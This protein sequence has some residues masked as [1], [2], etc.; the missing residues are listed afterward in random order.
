MRLSMIVFGARHTLKVFFPPERRRKWLPA[1]LWVKVGPPT[2]EYTK[3]WVGL[4]DGERYRWLRKEYAES[5][6]TYLAECVPSENA[7]DEYIDRQMAK[8]SIKTERWSGK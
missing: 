1:I 5:R 6:E 8:T 4:T 3:P 7:L 2:V